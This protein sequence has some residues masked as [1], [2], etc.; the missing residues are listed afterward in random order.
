MIEHQEN[1]VNQEPVTPLE[2]ENASQTHEP[3]YRNDVEG[4]E[5]NPT[6]QSEDDAAKN[7]KAMRESNARLQREKEEAELRAKETAD[8][9]LRLEKALEE[10]SRPPTQE[11][12]DELAD[13]AKDDWTTREHVEK[14]AERQAKA[15]YKRLKDEDD[16]VRAEQEKKRYLEELPTKIKAK[17]SDFDSVVTKENVD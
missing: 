2:S 1:D 8:R 3:E 16:K 11:E 10:Q 12:I 15:M 9:L 14:L 17:H 4:T 13:V 6:V 7:F 5:D